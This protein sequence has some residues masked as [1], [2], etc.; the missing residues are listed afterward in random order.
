MSV[1]PVQ[2]L[3][4][5]LQLTEAKGRGDKKKLQAA[6]S[7][8]TEQLQRAEQFQAEGFKT[9]PPTVEVGSL[10][11]VIASEPSYIVALLGTS[12]TE[13]CHLVHKACK[14]ALEHVFMHAGMESGMNTWEDVIFIPPFGM[15]GL[16]SQAGNNTSS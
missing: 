5:V 4:F 2:H 1:C 8:A 12:F 11:D 13:G 9:D 15:H 10:E 6:I 14:E 7:K 3:D 16:R